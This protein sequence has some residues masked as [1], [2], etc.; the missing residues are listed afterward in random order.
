LARIHPLHRFEATK[1]ARNYD[2]GNHDLRTLSLM[3]FDATIERMGLTAGASHEEIV[4]ALK[5]LIQAAEPGANM[6]RVTEV[7]T[8]VVSFL[9]NE[10]GRRR[11]VC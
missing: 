4:G 3:V 5:P 9:L 7:A 2:L 11:A 6:Q 10:D 1:A 8:A